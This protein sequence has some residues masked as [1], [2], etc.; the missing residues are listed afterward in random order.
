MVVSIIVA[1]VVGVVVSYLVVSFLIPKQLNQTSEQLIRL[2]N[3][4]L[5]AEKTAV[6][7]IAKRIREELEGHEGKL[8]EAERERIGSFRALKQELENQRKI[9]EQLSATTEGL[10]KVLSNNQLRGQ[11][12]EQVAEELLTMSGFVKGVNYEFNKQQKESE[13]RPDFTI[14]LPNKV[15]INVDV[16]FPYKNLQRMTETDDSSLKKE[17]LKSFEKDIR[18]KIKQVTT[19]DYINPQD[20][21]VDFVMMF[22]PN[23]MIF[24][25]IYDKMPAVWTDA[26]RQKVV[27]AGPFSFTAILRLVRQAYDNFRYQ[28]DVQKIIGYIKTFEVE[29]QKY[30]EEFLKIGD[31]ISSLTN[32]YDMVNKTRTNQLSRSIDKVKL[33]ENDSNKLLD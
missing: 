26:M 7:E 6:E 11:F 15:K 4:K 9:S 17:I 23:E 18:D 27:M 22:I 3:E 31:R 29:F 24:S 32:Q 19:R 20:N 8:E 16:K 28:K 12:G 25:F 33:E 2:A 10:K 21:T 14:F 30:N 5:G 1:V 13:T